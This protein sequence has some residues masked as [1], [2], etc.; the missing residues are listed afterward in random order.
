MEASY[1]RLIEG[2]KKWAKEKHEGV[3]VKAVAYTVTDSAHYDLKAIV[4]KRILLFGSETEN[5]LDV[6]PEY[7]PEIVH[8]VVIKKGN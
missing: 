7:G 6:A 5:D 3:Y 8:D 4:M 2:N 1:T